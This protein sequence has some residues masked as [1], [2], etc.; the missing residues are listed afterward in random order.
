MAVW[1]EYHPVLIPL[2]IVTFT[3]FICAEVL[4]PPYFNLA[5]GREITATSTCGETPA[6]RELYCRLTGATGRERTSGITELGLIQGQYC[7]FCDRNDPTKEHPVR[8]A[9]DGTERWWQSPP[10]SRGMSYNAVNLTINL[11]QVRTESQC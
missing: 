7:D 11:G 2:L 9:I 6:G 8:F 10:L 1:G 5:Q 4:T 3:Q